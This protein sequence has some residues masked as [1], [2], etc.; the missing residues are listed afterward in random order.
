MGPTAL[1]GYMTPESA[2]VFGRSPAQQ[3]VAGWCL[4]NDMHLMEIV[5]TDPARPSARTSERA[6]AYDARFSVMRDRLVRICAGFVGPD[7]AE[8]VAHDAYLR[9]RGKWHQ[10]RDNDLLEAWLTRLAINLCLNRHRSARRLL[11]R[12]RSLVTPEVDAPPR[13]VGLRDLVERLAP[14]ERTLIVLHYGHGYTFEE[15]AGLAGLSPVNVRTIVFRARRRLAE[16]I[17]DR[18]A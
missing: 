9:G 4:P 7:A 16:Q 15:I 17:G 12:F 10:L 18:D 11:D 14:R 1:F 3:L 6:A 2:R 13:D 5:V 8:D